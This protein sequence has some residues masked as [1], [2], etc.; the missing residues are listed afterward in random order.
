VRF[1]VIAQQ[2]AASADR[3]ERKEADRL[4]KAS[5]KISVAGIITG[6]VLVVVII[7]LY[8][9]FVTEAIKQANTVLGGYQNQQYH[10]DLSSRY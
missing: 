9:W 3:E 1:I 8:V 10:A 2:K 6:V 7:V 5:C 4:A